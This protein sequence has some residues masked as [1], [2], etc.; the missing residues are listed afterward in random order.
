MRQLIH[1]S[2]A[3]VPADDIAAAIEADLA[4]AKARGAGEEG[5][6]LTRACFV[7]F[8]SWLVDHRRSGRECAYA[9]EDLTS[10]VSSMA[11]TLARC[12][13]RP[14]GY[15]PFFAAFLGELERRL[16]DT[17]DLDGRA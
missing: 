13:L 9:A 6:A 16:R 3:D 12:C 5:I 4:I 7:P 10:L 14:E 15:R 1:S 11:C 2:I 8:M 17:L